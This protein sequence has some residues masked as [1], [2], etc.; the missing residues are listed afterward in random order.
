M[1]LRLYP[2]FGFLPWRAAETGKLQ[3]KKARD[4]PGKMVEQENFS[5]ASGYVRVQP[6]RGTW[7]AA[8]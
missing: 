2:L 4:I 8:R 3:I 1:Q 5:S 6:P 7:A